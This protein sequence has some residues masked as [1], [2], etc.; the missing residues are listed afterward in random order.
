MWIN[1]S[2]Q[3][4]LYHKTFLCALPISPQ[5]TLT[6]EIY[7]I[8][9][10][11]HIIKFLCVPHQWSSTHY[12]HHHMT[13]HQHRYKSNKWHS[14]AQNTQTNLRRSVRPIHAISCSCHKRLDKQQCESVALCH[15]TAISNDTVPTHL[16]LLVWASREAFCVCSWQR[17]ARH[18]Y[19]IT[20]QA[21]SYLS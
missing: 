16:Q 20:S 9:Y 12:Q 7:N 15:V 1:G 18:C 4:T 21:E 19:N 14:A 8:S 17:S 3:V 13:A 6:I 11:S 2:K 10:N 5:I